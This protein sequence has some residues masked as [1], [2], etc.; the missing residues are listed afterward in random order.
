MAATGSADTLRNIRRGSHPRVDTL[1]A[2]CRVLGLEVQLGP[3]LLPP[4]EDDVVPVREPTEFTGARELPVYAWTDRSEA[5]YRRQSNDG[6]RAP[7]PVD[8]SDELAFYLRVPDGALARAQIAQGDYCLVSPC[9][10]LEAD[11]RAWFRHESGR[12]TL[13]WILRLSGAGFDLGAWDLDERSRPRPSR[14]HWQRD[15]VVDRGVVH[16]VYRERPT[17]GKVLQ[18]EP[19]WRPDA[20]AELFRAGLLSDDLAGVSAV[21][22]E[23]VSAVEEAET[24]IKRLAASDPIS[25][26]HAELLLRVIDDSL[27]SSLTRARSSVIENRS[28]TSGGP[29]R[30]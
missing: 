13:K 6:D 12:E 4:R 18:P 23:A 1:E 16:A 2:L 26:S 28:D 8:M 3:G 17:A 22:E 11:Q 14:V 15:A 30:P 10:A 29:S 19:D 21:L 27:D 20:R 25:V 7:A 5:G 9:A 24:Q